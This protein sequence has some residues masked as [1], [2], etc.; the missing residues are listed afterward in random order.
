MKGNAMVTLVSN[1]QTFREFFYEIME[2]LNA[3]PTITVA[4]AWRR[5]VTPGVL[6]I[7]RGRVVGTCQ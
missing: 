4:I 2:L 5:A 1:A 3:D 7:E 6:L